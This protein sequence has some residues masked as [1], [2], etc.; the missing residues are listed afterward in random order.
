VEGVDGQK[1]DGGDDERGQ[2]S[3]H[4]TRTVTPES[5]FFD[6][7]IATHDVILNQQKTW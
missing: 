5:H 2:G 1:D 3:L 6:A 4:G 7:A